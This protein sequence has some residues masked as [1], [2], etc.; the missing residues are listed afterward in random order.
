MTSTATFPTDCPGCQ[1]DAKRLFRVFNQGKCLGISHLHRSGSTFQRTGFFD[2][3]KKAAGAFPEKLIMI[4]I[5]EI[6]FNCRIHHVHLFQ[7]TLK[8]QKIKKIQKIYCR[9]CLNQIREQN[10]V[11]DTPGIGS[12]NQCDRAVYHRKSLLHRF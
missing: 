11:I 4:F 10:Q 7:K 6:Y 8:A 3:M 5:T 12:A 9:V 2:G 1:R